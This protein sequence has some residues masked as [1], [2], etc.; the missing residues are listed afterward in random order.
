[1][2]HIR[3]SLKRTRSQRIELDS[4]VLVGLR[5]FQDGKGDIIHLYS[6][7]HVAQLKNLKEIPSKIQSVTGI[8]AILNSDEE[9]EDDETGFDFNQI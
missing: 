1:M 3:N 6:K 2:C 9:E 4:I 7:E 8:D 5:D